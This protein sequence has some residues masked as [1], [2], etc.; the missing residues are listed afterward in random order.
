MTTR[1]L[2]ALALLPMLAIAAEH[3]H[4]H[5]HDHAHDNPDAHEHGVARLN[6]VLDDREL[7][8]ELDSPAANLLGFEHAP[9]TDDERRQAA[10]VRDTLG[11]PLTWL[12]LAPAAG[13]EVAERDIEGAALQADA[14]DHDHDHDDDH[15]DAEHS[16]AA[17]SDIDARYRLACA[18][19]EALQALDLSAFFERFPGTERLLVQLIGPNGQTGTQLSAEQPRLPF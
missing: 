3:G 9:A 15:G 8:V 17:H 7:L 14:D 5:D 4:D 18:S 6:L 2:P 10:A 12:G 1:L 19:P 16:H 11:Q 13:C